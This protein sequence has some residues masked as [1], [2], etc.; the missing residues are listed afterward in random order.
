MGESVTDRKRASRHRRTK[1]P[2]RM[3][4]TDRDKKVIRAV[5]DFRVM[6]QEQVQH[7]LFPSKNTAQRRLQLLWQHGFLKREFPLVIGGV[8]TSTIYYLVDRRGTELLQRELGYDK[9]A[10]RWSRQKLN[11]RFLKHTLGLSDI[12]LAVSLSCRK[13]DPMEID[14]S[15]ESWQDE[16]ALKA[17]YDKVQ[18]KNKMVAVLPDAYFV[19]KVP[20]GVL[21]FFLEFDRGPEHLKFFRQ[22]I[23]AYWYYFHSPK[24][25]SRYGTTK[26]RVLTVTEGGATRSGRERLASVQKVTKSLGAHTWFWFTSLEEVIQEDFLAAPIWWQ[27]HREEPSALF[28][29]TPR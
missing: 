18:I 23:S 6:S 17:S 10:L 15:I 24:P 11:Q 3:R 22:K 25:Q 14:F 4:L 21:R 2:P 26:I 19:V 1:E 27:T 9:T 20:G 12:R 13:H 28:T 16:K 29:P 8:Q 7:L 5:N